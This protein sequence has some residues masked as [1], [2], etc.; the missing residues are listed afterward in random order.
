MGES[1]VF[2]ASALSAVV[3]GSDSEHVSSLWIF[4][5]SI[6]HKHEPY[7]ISSPLLSWQEAE[8]NLFSCLG[9]FCAGGAKGLHCCIC[10]E[11][12]YAILILD[13]RITFLDIWWSS[14]QGFEYLLL[15]AFP[16]VP[17]AASVSILYFTQLDQYLHSSNI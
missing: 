8:L 14:G 5:V 16:C 13:R 1:F 6:L 3:G 2:S 17:A 15:I 4:F 10:H 9:A 7:L 12:T 11:T